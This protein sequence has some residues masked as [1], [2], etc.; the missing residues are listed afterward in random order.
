MGEEREDP[1][2]DGGEDDGDEDD[3]DDESRPGSVRKEERRRKRS[4]KKTYLLEITVGDIG[5]TLR[6]LLRGTSPFFS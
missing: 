3:E 5:R 4:V 2:G 1:H 6:A